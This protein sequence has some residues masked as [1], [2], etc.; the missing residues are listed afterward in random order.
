MMK[1]AIPFSVL[2][3]AGA[4]LAFSASP[5]LSFTLPPAATDSARAALIL[6]SHD[7]TT[8][9]DRVDDCN[10]ADHKDCD[11]EH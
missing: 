4:G 8:D 2:L 11:D 10:K 5:S 1:P 6:A 3:V 7:A 9:E